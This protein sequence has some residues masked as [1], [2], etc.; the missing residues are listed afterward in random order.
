MTSTPQGGVETGAGSTT[1][2]ENAGLISVGAMA[3]ISGGA[4]LARRRFSASN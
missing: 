3:A 4:L 1:G 2:I